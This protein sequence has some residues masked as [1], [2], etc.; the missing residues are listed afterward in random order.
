MTR[1]EYINYPAISASRIKRFYTGDIS[2]NKSVKAAL[3]KGA[4][5]HHQLLETDP[6]EMSKDAYNVYNAICSNAMLEALF[7]GSQKEM[8][9][10]DEI[11]IPYL[12]GSTQNI[13]GKGML[14]MVYHENK[15][16]VDI[17]TTNC[18]TIEQFAKDMLKHCNHIQAVWYSMLMG[19]SAKDF[20]YIGVPQ[21]AKKNGSTSSDLFLY[22]HSDDEIIHAIQLIANFLEQFDGN[23]SK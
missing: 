6:S 18:K 15:V 1:E 20:Y 12:D 8:I 14:D 22:R 13:L 3:D 10:V 9:V 4:A 23:F 11:V 5:F 2:I 19:W 17:K 16:I 21:K 7:N